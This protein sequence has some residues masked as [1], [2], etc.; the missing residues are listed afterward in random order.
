MQEE[1]YL[2]GAMA[3]LAALRAVDEK[4][5][6]SSQVKLITFGQPRVGDFYLSRHINDVIPYRFNFRGDNFSFR[7]VNQMDI[8]A[9]LPA[10]QKDES[11]PEKSKPC[12]GKNKDYAYHH[13]TEIWLVHF[14]IFFFFC[15][16][17]SQ[18][19]WNFRANSQKSI[20][21]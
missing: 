7:V 6:Q 20:T 14:F 8:V 19:L 5:R 3:S 4:L 11:Y 10:C 1:A 21:F 2:G 16:S 17:H 18:E 9:H 13:G 15:F 12:L